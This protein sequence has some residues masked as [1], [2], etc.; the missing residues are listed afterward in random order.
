MGNIASAYGAAFC[1]LAIEQHEQRQ[2]I[3][4]NVENELYSLKFV[5][6]TFKKASTF[7]SSRVIFLPNTSQ[8]EL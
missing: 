8:A 2:D 7:D 6:D 4:D 5:R 1:V 3:F